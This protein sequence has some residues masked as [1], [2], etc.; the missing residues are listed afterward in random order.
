M[1]DLEPQTEFDTPPPDSVPEVP[2]APPVATQEDI[3]ALRGEL[4]TQ[5]EGLDD[6]KGDAAMVRKLREVFGGKPA[7]PA[8][9]RDEFVRK[10]IQRL[11]P[12]LDD[13]DKIKQVLPQIIMAM[14]AT[15]E[16]RVA[17]RTEQ[18]RDHLRTLMPD[19]GLDPKDEDAA[20]YLEQT[21]VTELQRNKELLALW[22]RG[23]VKAS[24]NKALDK[25]QSKLFA[26]IRARA[27]RGAVTNSQEGPKA[28]PRGGAA[29]AASPKPAASKEIDVTTR[30][31]ARANHDAAF[32]Y[33]QDLLGKE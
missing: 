27:K 3:A 25:V 17:E 23:N 32:E 1:A 31:G 19:L 15:V 24:V 5:L 21:L 30:E 33:L 22:T 26:P 11:V 18:A 10:E 4:K 28:A 16:E 6:L 14:E 8:N 12:E 7:G 29:P 20:A 13:L 9:P 2:A